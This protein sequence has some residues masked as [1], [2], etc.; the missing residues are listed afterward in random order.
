MYTISQTTGEVV[1]V[2]DGKVISPC[3]SA[4]DADFKAYIEWVMLED[5][6][7]IEVS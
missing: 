3:Q 4:D 2:A 1:R 6:Q 7:P 5:N